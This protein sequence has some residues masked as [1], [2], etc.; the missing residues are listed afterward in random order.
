MKEIKLKSMSLLN[1]KGA[2]KLEIN[3]SKETEIIGANKSGKSTICDAFWWVLFGKDS[4]GNEKF[5]VKTFDSN[6]NVIPK[7]A[8]EVEVVI[9]VAGEDVKLKRCLVEKWDDEKGVLKGNTTEYYYNDVP[10]KEKEYKEKINA[11]CSEEI[12]K[13]IT[14]I[15]YFNSLKTEQKRAIVTNIA[16]D[17]NDTFIA[18][19]NKDYKKLLKDITGKT[20]E[21]FK[22]E[23]ATKIAK[24]KEVKERIPIQIDECKR[25]MPIPMMWDEVEKEIETKKVEFEKLNKQASDNILAIQEDGKAFEL[26]Q[27]ELNELTS[28]RNQL[29]F[30][31]KENILSSTNEEKSKQRDIKERI[32][33]ANMVLASLANRKKQID[34]AIS[35]KSIEKEQLKADYE[36]IKVQTPDFSNIITACPTCKKPFEPYEIEEEQ[37]EIESNFNSGRAKKIGAI[38]EKGKALAIEIQNLETEKKEISG[39]EKNQQNSI[40]ELTKGIKTIAEPSSEE[41]ENAVKGNVDCVAISKQI[42]DLEAAIANRP[43]PKVSDIPEKQ[44]TLQ[45]EIQTL[46]IELS[47]K[48]I[49]DTKTKRVAELESQLKTLANEIAQ[50]QKQEAVIKDFTKTRMEKIEENVNKLFSFTKFK[51][52]EENIGEGYKDVCIAL[53]NGTPYSDT[54]TAGKVNVALDII[55]TLC[56][57][58]KVSAPVFIDNRESVT[59]IIPCISQIINLKVVEG[60]SLTIQNK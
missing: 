27:K 48:E 6:N 1:F 11:I 44:K 20:L 40:E 32:D 45:E 16:G 13:L 21:E 23:I 34:E 3:F 14:S 41:I 43:Q 59:E 7:L 18:A 38:N 35:L 33:G 8:H 56:K 2:R 10:L 5:G 25:D 19:G 4:A 55:N 52:F 22:K 60:Q 47:K 50:L 42:A 46:K 58:Y 12:F 29:A 53:D 57:H 28:K 26:R 31:I 15:T 51:M 30:S 17:I 37:S 39:K 9:S 49:I 54:N 24:T 36:K